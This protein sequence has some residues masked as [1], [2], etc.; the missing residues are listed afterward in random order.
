AATKNTPAN[1]DSAI[2]RIPFLGRLSSA[3]AAKGT[4]AIVRAAKGKSFSRG[5]T[6]QELQQRLL[7]RIEFFERLAFDAR[8][9]RRC[10]PFRLRYVDYGDDRAILVEG[11]EGPPRIK[12]LRHVALRWSRWTER[13]EC[14]NPSPSA[15]RP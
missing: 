13:R 14:H 1:I 10:Q 12:R 9:N 8:N 6:M 2:G 11:G 15:R 3:I 7:I 4:A 5:S